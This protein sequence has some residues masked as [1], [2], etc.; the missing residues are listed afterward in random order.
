MGEICPNYW[1]GHRKTFNNSSLHRLIAYFYIYVH[2]CTNFSTLLKDAL[3]RLHSHC[4][5][6]LGTSA[7]LI[8]GQNVFLLAT[9]TVCIFH[10]K[11]IELMCYAL[12]KQ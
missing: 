11:P 12:Y 1:L 10:L 9:D 8:P 4:A 2:L 5:L 3:E 7:D 6:A